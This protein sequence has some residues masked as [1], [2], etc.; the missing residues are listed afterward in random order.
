MRR[1]ISSCKSVYKQRTWRDN[2]TLPGLEN[3]APRTRGPSAQARI[4]TLPPI[5]KRSTVE[6]GDERSLTHMLNPSIG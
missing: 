4:D 1:L 5:Q 3:G 6:S 2:F